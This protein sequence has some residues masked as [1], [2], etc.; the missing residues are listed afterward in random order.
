MQKGEKQT[1]NYKI[2]NKHQSG[3]QWKLYC[4]Q[5]EQLPLSNRTNIKLQHSFDDKA[6]LNHI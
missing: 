2:G 1:T 3:Y 4:E 6:F 5:I